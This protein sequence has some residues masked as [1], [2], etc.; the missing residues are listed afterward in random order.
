MQ[1]PVF[2]I[3]LPPFHA[4]S[5][6]EHLPLLEDF[7]RN[8]IQQILAVDVSYRIPFGSE[9]TTVIEHVPVLF[10]AIPLDRDTDWAQKQELLAF[11]DMSLD[12]FR[13]VALHVERVFNQNQNFWREPLIKL[14]YLGFTLEHWV[15]EEPAEALRWMPSAIRLKVLPAYLALIQS[16]DDYGTISGDPHEG[17]H[18]VLTLLLG[19]LVAVREVIQL[20]PISALPCTLHPYSNPTIVNMG[21][22]M[23]SPFALQRIYLYLQ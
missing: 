9:W 10:D 1:R 13:L 11:V 3:Q 22:R 21:N 19:C 5:G 16:L 4:A 20:L 23:V 18:P 6:Q 7:L 15:G 8:L 12:A 2:K 17:E 14:L